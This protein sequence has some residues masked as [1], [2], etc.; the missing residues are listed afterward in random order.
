M[1]VGTST[2]DIYHS[3][4]SKH[5]EFLTRLRTSTNLSQISLINKSS[6]RLSFF[7]LGLLASTASPGLVVETVWVGTG[8]CSPTGGAGGSGAGGN[9]DRFGTETFAYTST[10][11]NSIV[12]TGIETS[13]IV[14]ASVA[15][16]TTTVV[17]TSAN[18]QKAATTST[19]TSSTYP[20]IPTIGSPQPSSVTVGTG[21]TSITNSLGSTVATTSTHVS[22]RPDVET[23]VYPILSAST[24]SGSTTVIVT[25]TNSNDVITM[26]TTAISTSPNPIIATTAS[27]QPVPVTVEIGTTTISLLGSTI[28]APSTY[29]TGTF[30]DNTGAGIVNTGTNNGGLAVTSTDAASSPTTNGLSSTATNSGTEPTYSN[31]SPTCSDNNTYYID[32][33]GLQYDIRCGLGFANADVALVAH[34]DTFEG[35]I[36]Y[37]SLLDSCAGAYFSGT[38]CTPLAN[39]TG[40][41]PDE[42][43]DLLTAVPMD[44]HNDGSVTPDNLCAEGFDGQTYTDTFECTWNIS[45]NQTIAGTALQSTIVTNLEACINYC[46]FYDGCKSLYFEGTN[47][48]ASYGEMNPVANCY[49]LSSNDGAMSPSTFSSSATLQ[50]TCDWPN[51]Q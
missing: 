10:N 24:A 51:N 48:S 3:R 40:Y 18:P 1:E 30:A 31:I 16:A 20:I 45:C 29:V 49:P 12:T 13:T 46:A 14:P 33:F 17:V 38:Q 27:S 4:G 26:S 37:C 9:H 32:H 47:G 5:Q 23:S 34:T 22:I 21:T 36:Q 8:D 35:C 2:R 7:G 44:G 6:M 11:S 41:R 19:T 25:S 15:S 39:F 43:S 28:V 50:G 42:G